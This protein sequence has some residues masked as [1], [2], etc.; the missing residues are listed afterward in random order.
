LKVKD[1]II[2]R[3]KYTINNKGGDKMV[4]L[5][6]KLGQLSVKL[7]VKLPEEFRTTS[8]K[9]IQKLEKDQ[10]IQGLQIGEVAPEFTLPDV[11]GGNVSLKDV[12]AEGPVV[13]S[14]YRGSW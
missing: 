1:V 4:D 12:L 8:A 7:S 13:L 5:N 14:F 11:T 9:A 3:I 2:I 10:S 6:E